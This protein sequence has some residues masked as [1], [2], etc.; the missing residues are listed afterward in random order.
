MT[1]RGGWVFEFV[2]LAATSSGEN[3][4]DSRAAID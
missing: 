3:T 4:E 1:L 2:A